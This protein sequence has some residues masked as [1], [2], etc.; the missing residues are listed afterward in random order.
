M[1][2][3][4][5][6]TI[7]QLYQQIYG[8]VAGQHPRQNIF[9]HQFFPVCYLRRDLSRVLPELEGK[10]I[11][12][13]C[14]RAP[15]RHLLKD[16]VKYTGIDVESYPEVDLEVS[17]QG[18]WPIESESF[19]VVLSFQVL[20]HVVETEVYLAELCRVLRPGGMLILSVPFLYHVHGKPDCRRWTEEGIR[21][22]LEAY[23]EIVE[24]ELEGGVGS[25]LVILILSWLDE[26]FTR[27]FTLRLLKAVLLP[28]FLIV[29]FVLNMFG[30]LVDQ[31]D[32][33]NSYYSNV[34]VIARRCD[35]KRG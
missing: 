5:P 3:K 16:S 35:S 25:T 1:S 14:G 20:E 9:H 34:L 30:K 19:D 7:A 17:P 11:D 4:A 24:V 32:S 23:F 6:S 21:K 33:T 10:V 31:I 26:I 27:S 2:S 29:N 18:D 28:V 12:A 13:G 22:L 15:Y 8:A